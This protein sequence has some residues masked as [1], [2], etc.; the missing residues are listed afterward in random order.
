M[1]LACIVLHS[2]QSFV[3]GEFEPIS[4]TFWCIIHYSGKIISDT[5]FGIF[6]ICF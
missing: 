3:D 4:Y 6:M 2:C 1:T 5:Y